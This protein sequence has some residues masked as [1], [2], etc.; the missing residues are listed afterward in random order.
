MNNPGI[1]GLTA[2]LEHLLAPLR[3]LFPVTNRSELKSSS[4]LHTGPLKFPWSPH[5]LGVTKAKQGRK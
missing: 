1:Q 4:A 3:G 5:L 2:I